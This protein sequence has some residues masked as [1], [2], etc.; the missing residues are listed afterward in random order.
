MPIVSFAPQL[1]PH[2]PCPTP[3][4]DAAT[5]ADALR[6]GWFGGGNDYPG[7]HAICVDPRDS[8]RV[9]I[10][11]SRGGVWRTLD[12]GANWQIFG[13][14]FHAP[15]LPPERDGDANGKDMHAMAAGAAKPEVIDN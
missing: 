4:V 10:A 13:K 3:R 7:L 11:I 15:Y 14:G 9:T 8:N 2:V 6:K 12:A 1:Q 5:L